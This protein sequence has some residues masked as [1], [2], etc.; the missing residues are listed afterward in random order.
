M[1]SALGDKRDSLARITLLADSITYRVLRGPVPRL[2][3]V[4][5]GV[6]RNSRLGDVWMLLVIDRL[7]APPAADAD[8]YIRN[9]LAASID[10]LHDE[11]F[12]GRQRKPKRFHPSRDLNFALYGLIAGR[13]NSYRVLTW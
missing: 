6:P 7:G 12:A 5:V 4:P 1:G 2:D 3:T 10:N 8:V 13:R 11:L 9:W